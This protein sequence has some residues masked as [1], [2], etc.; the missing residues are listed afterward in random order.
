MY[1]FSQHY[2]FYN[3]QIIDD[4]NSSNENDLL[5]QFLCIKNIRIFLQACKV[6]FDLKDTD[7]FDPYDLFDMKNFGKVSQSYE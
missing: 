4:Y 5:F 7:L 6:Y 1:Y 2:Y 3:S